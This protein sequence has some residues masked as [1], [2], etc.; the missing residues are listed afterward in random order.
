MKILLD[1]CIHVQA[2]RFFPTH[3]VAHARDMG[4]TELSNGKLLAAAHAAGFSVLVTVDKNLRFQQNLEKPPLSVIELDVLKNRMD[5]IALL[6]PLLEEALSQARA[7]K[8]VS[9]RHDRTI[10]SLVAIIPNS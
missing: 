9:L 7:F 5:E 8:F 1:N 3:E 6:A 10:E 2:T 4:W